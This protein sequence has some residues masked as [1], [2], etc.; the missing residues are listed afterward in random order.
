VPPPASACTSFFCET[1]SFW[2]ETRRRPRTAT[3]EYLLMPAL[4]TKAAK[5]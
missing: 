5:C 4:R 3:R 2:Q 1:A